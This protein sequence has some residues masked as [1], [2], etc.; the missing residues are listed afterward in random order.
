MAALAPA[1]HQNPHLLTVDKV[2]QRPDQMVDFASV[3]EP[4]IKIEQL[5]AARNTLT[6]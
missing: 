2:E 6:H 5:M 1:R 3:N 4:I